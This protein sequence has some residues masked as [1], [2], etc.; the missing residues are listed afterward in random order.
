MVMNDDYFNYKVQ[1]PNNQ[2]FKWYFVFL[3]LSLMLAKKDS[4]TNG[5]NPELLKTTCKRTNFLRRGRGKNINR[6]RVRYILPERR[7]VF[8]RGQF[9]IQVD[10]LVL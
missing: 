5:G 1:K 9:Q 3:F 4:R 2:C 7:D 8:R 10:Q 6:G